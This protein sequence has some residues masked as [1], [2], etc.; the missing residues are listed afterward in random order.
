MQ[1]RG[2]TSATETG[3]ALCLKVKIEQINEFVESLIMEVNKY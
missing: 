2:I 1:G 3:P